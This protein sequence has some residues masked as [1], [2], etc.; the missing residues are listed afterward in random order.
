MQKLQKMNPP[1]Q[2]GTARGTVGNL[3]WKLRLLGLIV[4]FVAVHVC[5][6]AE[7]GGSDDAQKNDAAVRKFRVVCFGDSITKRGYPKL[8]GEMLGVDAINAGV[9]GNSSAAGLRRIQ[10]DVLDLKPDVVVIFFGTNDGRV[11]EPRVHVPAD[12]YEANLNRMVDVCEKIQARVVLCTLPPVNETPFYTRHVKETF[13]A[14]GGLPKLWAE[15]RQAAL[16]VGESRKLPVVDLNQKLL[17]EPEWL[18]PDGVHPT[19]AGNAIIARMI[20]DAV[21]PLIK[22]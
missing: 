11:D 19:D 3:T 22:K 15:Y 9:G 17:Q 5:V 12:K 2:L 21:R 13:E 14:A 7:V 18:S 4:A 1:L 8:L 16:R 6:A 10:K 20:A